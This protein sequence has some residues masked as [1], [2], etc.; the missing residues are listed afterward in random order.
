MTRHN[1]RA[2]ALNTTLQLLIIYKLLI[3]NIFLCIASQVALYMFDQYIAGFMVI[4]GFEDGINFVLLEICI[5][6]RMRKFY[7]R[8]LFWKQNFYHTQLANLYI[9]KSIEH[10]LHVACNNSLFP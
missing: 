10:I 2:A 8:F 6:N 9:S 4:G 1:M 3:I 5:R 7:C